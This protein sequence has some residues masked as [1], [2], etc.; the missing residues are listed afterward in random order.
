MTL[1]RSIHITPYHQ[2]GQTRP[3]NL[4]PLCRGHHRFK[5]SGRGTY[6]MIRPGT[7]HWTLPTGQ[8]LVDP[9]GTHDLTTPP[10]TAPDNQPPDE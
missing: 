9:T 3:S 7:Y 4:A 6:R 2:G 5:T 10:V 1:H 8:W